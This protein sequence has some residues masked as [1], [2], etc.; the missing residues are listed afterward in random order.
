MSSYIFMMPKFTS[1]LDG[2][3]VNSGG[4]V[5]TY[6]AGTTTQLTTYSD[7]G[8]TSKNTNPVVLDTNGQASIYY[9]GPFK[10]VICDA[11]GVQ[12]QTIDNLYGW[13]GGTAVA[14]P[15]SSEGKVLTW[16]G[17]VLTNSSFTLSQYGTS[18]ASSASNAALSASAA[19]TSATNASVSA[20][21]ASNYANQA[22]VVSGNIPA[23]SEGTTY[24][25][26]NVVAYTDGNTYRCIGSGVI[27]QIPSQSASWVAL[28]VPY[29]DYFNTDGNGDLMPS[30]TPQISG[31]FMIDGN[32]DIEPKS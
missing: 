27:G 15:A 31:T 28:N 26:P 32:G 1:L 30:L 9:G 13:G 25:Y 3:G 2:G 29:Q 4:S 8:L 14:F 12:L 19:S 21:S 18:A 5:Y 6:K 7:V 10:V 22:A 23:W 16:T 20:A 11:N 17:G 24:N